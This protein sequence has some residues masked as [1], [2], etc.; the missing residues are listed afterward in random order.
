[1]LLHNKGF[2]LR[3]AQNIHGAQQVHYYKAEWS[4]PHTI[5]PTLLYFVI[6][7]LLCTMTP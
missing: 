6:V 2:F 4:G 7:H 3:N 5:V 1:M